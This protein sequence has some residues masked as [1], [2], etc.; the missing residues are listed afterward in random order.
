MN[1]RWFIG[2][3]IVVAGLLALLLAMIFSFYSV[4]GHELFGPL[5]IYPCQFY[6]VP[7]IIMGVV[8]LAV[9]IVFVAIMGK[10]E[11]QQTQKTP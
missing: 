1:E 6:V 2:S 5:Y 4:E 8:L 10:D 11:K 3:L 9:G 7:S